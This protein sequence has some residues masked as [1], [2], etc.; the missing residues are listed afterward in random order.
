[1]VAPNSSPLRTLLPIPR[2]RLI[3]REDEIA[4]ARA[5]LLDDAV[6]LLTLT[7]PGG[8]GKTRLALAIATDVARHFGD[9]VVW[10]DLAPLRD[11]TLVPATLAAALAL[12]PA[13]NHS[14]VDALVRQLRSRQTLLLLDN[15]E[16]VVVAVAELVSVLLEHCPAV[17][18]LAT[19]RTPL[20]VR[21][22]QVLPVPTLAVPSAGI[23]TVDDIRTAPAVALFMQ[24]A[25][26]A[27]PRFAVTEQN[28][29]AV[30]ELCR[31]LDGLPLAIELAAARST[32]LTPAAMVALLGQRLQVFG[33]GPRD[34]PARQQT[35]R[36]A[37]GWSH[38]LLSPED[39]AVFRTLAVF[40]GGWTLEAAAA[41]SGLALP[42]VL[43]RLDALVEQ[44]LVVC[45]A[46]ANAV[47]PRFA[48]LETVRE[49][50]L[51]QLAE[52]GEVSLVRQRH[53]AYFRDL[54][55]AR[56][57]DVYPATL[58]D[59]A[60]MTRLVPEQDN[61]RQALAWF[62]ERGD[63]VSLNALSVALSYQW[64]I[65][66]QYAEG[67]SW[68]DKAMADETGVPTVVRF[69][70]RANAGWLAVT[71][72]EY[73]VAKPLLDQG[74]AL[75]REVG[76]P[77]LLIDA[78][79]G[80]GTLAYH[81]GELT[82]AAALHKEAEAVARDLPDEGALGP[83]SIASSLASLGAVTLSIGDM[84]QAT[85]YY[86]EGLSLAR[87]PGGAQTRSYCLCGLGYIRL[88]QR[89]VPEAAACFTEA[90]AIACMV[91]DEAFV[92]WLLWAIAATAAR[93]PQAESA[94]RLV[95]AADA[96]TARTGRAM[97][98]LDRE[99]ADWCLEQLET[100]LGAATFS[101]L[102]RAGTA[103][104][105]ESAVAAAYA[106]A[107]AILGHERVAAIWQETGTPAPQPLPGDQSSVADDRGSDT[108]PDGSTVG[109]TR[110]EREVLALLYQHHTDA[111]IADRFFLSPRT[112][113]HHVSSILGK[114][115]A[116]NRRDAVAI[117]ARLGLT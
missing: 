89:A 6:P 81:Q 32:T 16:H 71:Q 55:V 29:A 94:T 3:G 103:L 50:G 9:G 37:I 107:E 35:L 80:R 115:G 74:V 100:D 97:W 33:P 18:V 101:L 57:I 95:G 15:C 42:D 46:S 56:D 1:M 68:L 91:H 69:R 110:R 61:L 83:L 31:H 75:A 63:T 111:E 64:F 117:A 53:A 40:A 51:E 65:L 96:I 104:S 76:D 90:I 54:A 21:G 5:F 79:Q 62:A 87:V 17:Q 22:E 23:S 59:D 109:L 114:L 39:Q 84:T 105:I 41:I 10:V 19:S 116:T 112:V 45:Q 93:S 47:T 92:G 7:G 24:R 66:G 70:T 2:T 58:E 4:A 106:V 67:R 77:L 52:M 48:M 98:P 28:A 43:A 30:T 102:R 44:S 11:P 49:F 85:A 86:R 82:Q 99:L 12:V 88:R 8:V 25:R 38:A 72:G 36:D 73:D 20:R 34:A 13:P 27:D 78:L 113:Q 60:W 14:L 108:V 26:A